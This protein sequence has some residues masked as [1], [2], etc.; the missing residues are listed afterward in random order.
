MTPP[1]GVAI[2][3]FLQPKK[4]TQAERDTGISCLFMGLCF[5]TEGV[6]PFA[7]NDPLRFIPCSMVGSAIA[8]GIAMAAGVETPAA[9]GGIF[10]CG[11]STNPLMWL[12]AMVVGSVV[13]G[14]LYAIF[15]KKP[16]EEENH[17]EEVVDLDL[18]I[19]IE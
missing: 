17:E 15:K 8:G 10:V 16:V 13:T 2:A 1:I 18:D 11:L 19:N 6:L 3:T 12:V 5:I 14:I 7:A 9:H 4:F